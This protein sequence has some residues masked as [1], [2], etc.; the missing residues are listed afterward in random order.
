MAKIYLALGSNLGQR[1]ENIQKAIAE[2]QTHDIAVEKISKI[3]ETEPVGGPPQSKFLN[4][5]LQAQTQLSPN[6][7]LKLAKAIEKKLG[8]K[9]SAHHGPRLIDIDILLYDKQ[10]INTPSLIIPHPRMRERNF[11]MVSLREIDPQLVQELENENHTKCH[12]H[13]ATGHQA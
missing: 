8:R 1:G 4:A 6:E 2:L 5:V 13:A 7:L 3:I 9:P 12:G 11:V 10:K